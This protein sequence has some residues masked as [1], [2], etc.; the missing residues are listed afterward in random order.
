MLT[1]PNI[2]SCGLALS[3]YTWKFNEKEKC[4]LFFVNDNERL[5]SVVVQSLDESL[6]AFLYFG[7]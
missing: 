3:I 4:E 5:T 7:E 1:C 2:L 6:I